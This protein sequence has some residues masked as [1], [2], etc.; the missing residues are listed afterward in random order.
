[1]G[2]KSWYIVVFVLA[3]LAAAVLLHPSKTRQGKML[4]KSGEVEQAIASFREALKEKPNDPRT[5]KEMAKTLEAAGKTQE[6][7]K[8]F[9]K[10]LTLDPSDETYKEVKR[11]YTWTEQPKKAKQV[12]QTWYSYREQHNK[13]FKDEKGRGLLKDLYGYYLTDQQY[14]SAIDVLKKR[15]RQGKNPEEIQKIDGDLMLLYEKQGDLDTTIALLEKILREDSHNREALNKYASL[16]GISGKK[17]NLEKILEKNI[18]DNPNNLKAWNE[19]IEF[20]TKEKEFDRA[21]TFFEKMMARFP[22]NEEIENKYIEWFI[23]TEQHRTAIAYLEQRY[24]QDP[25]NPNYRKNLI[26]LYEWNDMTDEVLPF[27]LEDFRENPRSFEKSKEMAWILYDKGEHKTAKDVLGQLIQIHPRDVDYALMLISIYDMEES[28]GR[29]IPI[30]EKIVEYN[31]DPEFMLDLGERYLWIGEIGK[32]EEVFN[33]LIAMDYQEPKLYR[34]LGDIY[35][36]KNNHQQ[37]IKNYK[38]YTALAPN[39]YYAHYQLGEI[40]YDLDR[41]NKAY[42]E[43]KKSLALIDKAPQDI[44]IKT[45]E[46]RMYALLGDTKKSDELFAELRKKD[47][48]NITIGNAYVDTLIDTNRLHQAENIAEQYRQ[49][50]PK[51]YG[52]RSNFIRIY[53]NEYKYNK[54][55]QEALSLQHDYPEDPRVELALAEVYYVK[56]KWVEAMPLL[57]KLSKIYPGNLYIQRS[58]DDLFARYRPHIRVGFGFTALGGEFFYGPYANYY[59]PINNKWFVEAGYS[60]ERNTAN[61]VNFDPNYVAYTNIVNAAVK[62]KPHYTTTVGGGISN[63]LVDTSYVPA[64]FVLAEWN[65]PAYGKLSFDGF[66]N[67][68]LNDPVTGLFFE[69][70]TANLRINYEKLFIDRLFFQSAYESNWYWVNSSK[71]GIDIGDEFGREDVA[72]AGLSYYILPRNPQLRL[73]YQFYYSKLHV[74]NDYLALIP[75]IPESLRHD[76]TLGIFYEWGKWVVTDFYAFW[77]HDSKRGLSFTDFDLY[78]FNLTNTVKINRRMEVAGHY[79]YSSESLANAVGRYHFFNLEFLYRF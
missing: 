12:S 6:A 51:N 53:M 62:Y 43:F 63:Q 20:Q 19:L 38:K 29:A 22:A 70:R 66:Y 46:A 35:L 23:G 64:P 65:H 8:L 18:N 55:E 59:H 36:A 75:L 77:G 28:P 24:E 42:Q 27:Y 11:F 32:A 50:Y 16:S 67:K 10:L 15:R 40:Y 7:E 26:Q 52:L 58:Y 61:V 5:I 47:P 60:F 9:K 69:A 72:E 78:G 41:K 76:L 25:L 37:A 44:S 71:T 49:L 74:V 34:Y 79:E 3:L 21:N 39:D 17:A 73:G 30:M 54:A 33:E 31:K 48:N 4:A 68:I 14:N 57:D 56:G 45:Y 13:G 2:F 1:M